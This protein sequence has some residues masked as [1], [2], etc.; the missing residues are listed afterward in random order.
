M[1][2][3]FAAGSY[4]WLPDDDEVFVPAKVET[5]FSTGKVWQKGQASTPSNLGNWFNP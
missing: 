4:V 5:S 2:Q 1:S 3:V